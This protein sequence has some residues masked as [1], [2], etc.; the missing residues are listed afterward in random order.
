M[1]LDQLFEVMYHGS[2]GI[3]RQFVE[4]DNVG[5]ARLDFLD[6][7]KRAFVGGIIEIKPLFQKPLI[8]GYYGC[9]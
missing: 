6:G 8:T 4:A 3:T 1:N 5:Q 9:S 7:M 2:Q